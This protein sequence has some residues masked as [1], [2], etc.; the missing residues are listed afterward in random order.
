[1]NVCFKRVSWKQ[2]YTL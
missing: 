1:M 2:V